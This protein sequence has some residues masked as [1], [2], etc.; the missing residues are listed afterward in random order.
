MDT[1]SNSIAIKTDKNFLLSPITSA[2][3]IKGDIFI[4]FSISCGDTFLPPLVIMMSF[5]LSII[6]RNSPSKTPTSPV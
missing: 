4:L 1:V 5:F 6:F 2:S 3:L